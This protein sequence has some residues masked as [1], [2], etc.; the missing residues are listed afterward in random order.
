MNAPA[1]A[2]S[3]RQITPDAWVDRIY[4]QSA[5]NLPLPD[6][7]IGL[8]FTSPPY[9]VGKD[10]DDN[11]SLADYLGLME[12]VGKEVFR[13]LKPGGIYFINLS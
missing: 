5:E 9:N 3:P 4:C 2:E 13:V 7:S 10:Y 11:L 1:V 8:A 12:R 6:E